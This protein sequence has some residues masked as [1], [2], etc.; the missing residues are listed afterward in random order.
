[1]IASNPTP[2]AEPMASD[3]TLDICRRLWSTYHVDEMLHIPQET[4]VSILARFDYEIAA[5]A[6]ERDAFIGLSNEMHGQAGII[7][8]DLQARLAASEERS[9]RRRKLLDWCWS[10]FH[11]SMKSSNLENRIAAE[12]GDVGPAKV[13]P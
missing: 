13:G 4:G 3:R 2:P 9:E 1:M 10:R 7:A 5:L 6:R 12:I 11:A 8:R